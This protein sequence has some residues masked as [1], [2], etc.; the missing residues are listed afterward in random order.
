MGLITT[1]EARRTHAYILCL[2]GGILSTVQISVA[3]DPREL[4]PVDR[5][6][7]Q[8][9]SHVVVFHKTRSK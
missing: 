7:V 6:G 3:Y 5:P 9:V 1:S 8:C 2:A 4:D